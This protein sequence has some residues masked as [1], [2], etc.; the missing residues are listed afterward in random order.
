MVLGELACGAIPDR[1]RTL[2][3]LARLDCL[4]EL[5]YREVLGLIRARRLHGLGPGWV[6]WNLVASCLTSG[7]DLL[8]DDK[9]LA[10]CWSRLRSKVP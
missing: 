4:A 10:R 6:D 1:D 2:E 9:V 3:D 7:A 8:T 5:D